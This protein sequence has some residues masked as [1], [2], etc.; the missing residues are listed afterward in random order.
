[1]QPEKLVVNYGK[2]AI[3]AKSELMIFQSQKGILTENDA[4]LQVKL[5]GEIKRLVLSATKAVS[6]TDE[7]LIVVDMST[8]EQVLLNEAINPVL[9]TA[10]HIIGT[11]KADKSLL[12]LNC[13][14][15]RSWTAFQFP[16]SSII[17]SS[18]VFGSN[19]SGLHLIFGDTQQNIHYLDIHSGTL[20]KIKIPEKYQDKVQQI[21]WRE[22]SYE[23]DFK[24]V[25]YVFSAKWLITLAIYTFVIKGEPYSILAVEPAPEKLK[26][27]AITGEGKMVFH[28]DNGNILGTQLKSHAMRQDLN[29][30]DIVRLYC[31]GYIRKIWKLLKKDTSVLKRLARL[32]LN[33]LDLESYSSF[34]MA[35]GFQAEAVMIS[36][37]LNELDDKNLLIG[38]CAS[39]MGEFDIAEEHYLKSSTPK[40]A[41]Y[42]R[43]DMHEWEA[44]RLLAEKIAPEELYDIMTSYALQLEHNQ[45]WKESFNYYKTSLN[46]ARPDSDMNVAYAGLSRVTFRLGDVPQGLNFIKKLQGKQERV[47]VDCGSILESIRQFQEAAFLYEKGNSIDKAVEMYLKVKNY[48]KVVT[49]LDSVKDLKIILA[50]GNAMESE[51]NYNQ[52]LEAYKKARDFKS[53]TRLLLLNNEVEKVHYSQNYLICRQFNFLKVQATTRQGCW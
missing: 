52:A 40:E 35:D 43:R 44:A 14:S 32:S 6:M 33:I 1:V 12:Y 49:M 31:L 25:V 16:E 20:T 2:I 22:E 8:G 29:E 28:G 45:K 10:D 36:T 53:Q 41:V 27:L 23:N 21:L 37:Y 26:P 4:M 42:M 46:Y 30:N 13:Q 11:P 17:S 18:T 24:S 19:V 38:L 51:K 34:M 48:S 15:L 9:S 50:Y 3:A 39:I 7:A 5:P 47:Y